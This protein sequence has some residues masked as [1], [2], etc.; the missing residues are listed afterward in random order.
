[1][2]KLTTA[3]CLLMLLAGVHSET[4]QGRILGG[5]EAAN[6]ATPYA[7]SLRVDNAHVCGGSIITASKLLTAAHCLYRDGKLIDIS[8]IS[9]RVGSPNQY[10][11]G[12]VVTIA[13]YSI[14]PDYDALVNNLA[15]ITLNTALEW[16]DRIKAIELTGADEA[17]P[18][19]GAEISV[20][21]WGTTVD[22][23]SSFRIRKLNLTFASDEV[24][25]DAYSDHDASSSF[26]LAHALKEGTCNGDGGGAAVYNDKIL[27]VVNFV[28][29]A[30]GSRYPD[31]FVRVAGYSDWLQE[32]LLA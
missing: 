17:L 29:G 25:L 19:E 13:S 11:G 5:E 28:V 8:R 20:A 15:V 22:G 10:A 6:D 4:P 3:L 31:V 27:G 32:Q 23:V 18:A 12:H 2:I 30:C 26:C 14:H 16:T 9:A 21:G 24:C 7:V 1:M